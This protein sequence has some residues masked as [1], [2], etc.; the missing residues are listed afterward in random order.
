MAQARICSDVAG[1]VTA[2]LVSPGQRVAPGD[3]VA[4][5]ECMKME[6]P[7]IAE[8]AGVAAS[9]HVA[10]GEI[11]QEGQLIVILEL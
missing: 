2:V 3:Q 9:L 1:V 11:V 8:R 6:I 7:V 4:L 10:E 5:L